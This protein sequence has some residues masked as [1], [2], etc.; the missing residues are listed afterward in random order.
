[1]KQLRSLSVLTVS[2]KPNVYGPWPPPRQFLNPVL[3]S[4]KQSISIELTLSGRRIGHCL[5]TVKIFLS[6]EQIVELWWHVYQND[7]NVDENESYLAE[8]RMLR[9]LNK[10]FYA[11][12]QQHNQ[13]YQQTRVICFLLTSAEESKLG[14]DSCNQVI[15]RWTTLQKVGIQGWKTFFSKPQHHAF[16][17]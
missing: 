7:V 11:Q 15:H 13:K 3:C 8:V 4:S 17:K 9:F 16:S 14:R 10:S 2:A 6:T 12:Q 1:M 5:L